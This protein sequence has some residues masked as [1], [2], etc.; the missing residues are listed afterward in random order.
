MEVP[1][2]S[3]Q[4]RVRIW[5]MGD[6]AVLRNSIR[7][8]LKMG[9]GYP[10]LLAVLGVTL[11]FCFD[12]WESLRTSINNPLIYSEGSVICVMYYFFNSFSFGGVFSTYFAAIMAAIPFACNYC[13][14]VEGGMTIYKI[15]RCGS[16]AYVRSKFL[17]ASLLGGLT[18]LLGGLVFILPLTTYLPIVTPG[19]LFE[20]EWIPFYQALA[21]GNG[22]LYLV[23][24]LYISFLGGALWGSIGLCASAY[25]PSSYAAVCA[26]FVVRFMLVQ[27]G[28]LLK[29]PDSLRLDRLLTARGTIYSDSVTLILTTGIVLALIFLCCYLFTKRIKRRIWDVE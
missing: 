21:F 18:L 7:A 17:V 6:K 4:L 8:D 28:R 22:A 16:S 3:M 11:G 26:P 25:F 2:E 14:E 12:N 23:I 29:L 27:I 19:K 9:I 15:S 10:F 1:N 20:S 13:Q 24:V 5:H